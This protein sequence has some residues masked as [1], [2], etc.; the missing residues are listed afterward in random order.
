[1]IEGDGRPTGSPANDRPFP[2]CYCVPNSRIIA[3]EYP[4]DS[5]K[6]TEREKIDALLNWGVEVFIDLTEEGELPS[7]ESLLRDEAKARGVSAEYIRFPVRDFRIPSPNDMQRLLGLIANVERSGKKIY[8]HCWGGVGR[9][10]TAVGCYLVDRG[11]SPDEALDLVRTL[12]QEMSTEKLQRHP[13][14]SPETDAQRTFVRH[15]AQQR[16]KSASAAP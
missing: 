7:Y 14:G 16:S 4:V 3:G 5:D 2:N 12:F 10:G 1:M 9:T 11:Y 6:N 8:L 15:W 13:D